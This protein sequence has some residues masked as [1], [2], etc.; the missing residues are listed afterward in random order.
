MVIYRIYFVLSECQP[1]DCFFQHGNEGEVANS[2]DIE[3]TE[4]TWHIRK[5]RNLKGG[6]CI[7]ALVL[8]QSNQTM[9]ANGRI[10]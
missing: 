4:G 5:G 8:Y 1:L 7:Q 9:S 2:K 3:E 10:F 6:S